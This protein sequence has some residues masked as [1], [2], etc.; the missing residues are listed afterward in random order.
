VRLG[1]NGAPFYGEASISQSSNFS[2]VAASA[3]Q[4]NSTTS[5]TF[6]FDTGPSPGAGFFTVE[7]QAAFAYSGTATGPTGCFGVLEPPLRAGHPGRNLR[8]HLGR[9][10]GK[11]LRKLGTTGPVAFRDI[12]GNELLTL[13]GPTGSSFATPVTVPSSTVATGP[14]SLPNASLS[15]ANTSGLQAALD[16]KARREHTIPSLP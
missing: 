1:Q 6:F 9:G 15:I 11:R 8:L 12:A 10:P 5:Y 14:V 4:Q 3:V 16:S 13:F 7:S 2:Q